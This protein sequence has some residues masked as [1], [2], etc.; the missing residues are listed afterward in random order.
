[1]RTTDDPKATPATSPPT[2]GDP[3]R[4]CPETT[5]NRL[6]PQDPTACQAHPPISRHPFPPRSK[7]QTY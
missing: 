6:F 2:Q 1:M 4:A 3:T 7:L 5:T